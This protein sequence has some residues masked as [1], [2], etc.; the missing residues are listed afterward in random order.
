MI[1][2]NK[3]IP[4]VLK[5]ISSTIALSLHENIHK[6]TIK[7]PPNLDFF[8]LQKSQYNC[9]PPKQMQTPPPP[10]K[11]APGAHFKN[12]F[13]NLPLFSLYNVFFFII[14]N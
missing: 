5:Y 13:K 10:P 11:C 1:F 7:M 3:I 9:G 8:S 14:S 2:F 6:C 4:M 12:F